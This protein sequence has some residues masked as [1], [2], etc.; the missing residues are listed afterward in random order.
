MVISDIMTDPAIVLSADTSV[1]EAAAV[2]REN[3][4]GSVPVVDSNGSICGIVTDRDIVIRSI[5]EGLNTKKTKVL[6]IM[7]QNVSSVPP[8][9]EINDAFDIMSRD[10]VR[11]I[12]IV[13]HGKVLGVV[14]LGD[15]AL[16]RDYQIECANALCEISK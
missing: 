14:S 5:A 10:K 16:C 3:N 12:P 7:S 9:A 15:I 11:R 6:D 4:I 1:M 13:E 8:D 2:M